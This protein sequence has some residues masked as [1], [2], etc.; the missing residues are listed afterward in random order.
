MNI[1]RFVYIGVHCCSVW[2]FVTPWTAS[3]QAPLSSTICRNS[4]RSMSIELVMLSKHLILC[5][6]LLF[7]PPIFPSIRVFSNESAC[8]IR[9]PKYWSF[10]ISPSDVYSGLISF[11]VETGLISFRIPFLIPL[12]LTG[13]ISVYIY[14]IYSF[15]RS[16]VGKESACIAGDLG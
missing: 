16:S 1:Y 12:G 7:L 15:P 6:S 5:H 14:N 11:R 8:S 13:L 4:L 3:H 9:W 10:S 2:F